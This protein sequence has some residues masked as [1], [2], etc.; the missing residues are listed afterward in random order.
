MKGQLALQH[1][2]EFAEE[3][4]IDQ[5]DLAQ[6]I[7]VFVRDFRG[8]KYAR[9]LE[10]LEYIIDQEWGYRPGRMEADEEYEDME[11][12]AQMVYDEL[13]RYFGFEEYMESEKQKSS[14]TILTIQEDTRIPGTDYVLEKG[15]RV[16]V[17]TNTK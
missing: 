17:Y 10:Y 8:G 12:M 1:I 2:Q 13:V 16:K 15:D 4:G 3:N 9:E 14:E 5:F 11:M 6:G 7:N